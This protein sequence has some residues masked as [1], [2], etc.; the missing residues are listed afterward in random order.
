M[1]RFPTRPLG[2]VALEL[3]HLVGQVEQSAA[4]TRRRKRMLRTGANTGIGVMVAVA[5][6]T[7]VALVLAMERCL[8]YCSELPSRVG[9]AAA[10]CAEENTDPVVRETVSTIELLTTEMS[11]R[12]WA[13]ISLL[14]QA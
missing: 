12:I 13:K 8:D 10:L 11:R 4:V 9:Q 1:T 14:P 7:L 2:D 5:L 3:A 6:V